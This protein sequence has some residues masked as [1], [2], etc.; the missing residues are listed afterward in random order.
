MNL[1]LSADERL[2]LQRCFAKE[3]YKIK[4]LTEKEQKQR[5]PQKILA[6]KKKLDDPVGTSIQVDRND[7]RILEQQ[8]ANYITLMRTKTLPEY[9]KKILSDPAWYTPYRDTELQRVEMLEAFKGRIE[10]MLKK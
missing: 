9:E 10:E 3:A 7:L 2:W 1:E 4:G 5:L 8:T 6:L